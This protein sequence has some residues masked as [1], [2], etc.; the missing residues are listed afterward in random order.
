MGAGR[1]AQL[2]VAGPVGLLGASLPEA[3]GGRGAHAG[4]LDHQ[5]NLLMPGDSA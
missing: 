2:N 5:P 3:G 1:A 4:P